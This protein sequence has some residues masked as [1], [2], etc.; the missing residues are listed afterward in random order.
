MAK[1]PGRVYL[2]PLN[3]RFTAVTF[4][5]LEQEKITAAEGMTLHL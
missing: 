1:P 3:G 2:D 4:R 5:N